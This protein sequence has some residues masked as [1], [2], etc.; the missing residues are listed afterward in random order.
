MMTFFRNRMFLEGIA[1][2]GICGIII[3]SIIAFSLGES[4]VEALRRVIN[5]RIPGRSKV[6]FEYLSQ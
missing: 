3:G 4:S 5:E 1:L 6:P 2:G